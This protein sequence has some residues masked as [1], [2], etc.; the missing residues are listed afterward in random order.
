MKTVG[1]M[2]LQ[3]K[4]TAQA[5]STPLIMSSPV[6]IGSDNGCGNNAGG[7]PTVWVEDAFIE[8]DDAQIPIGDYGI[9]L[10]IHQVR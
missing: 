6:L 4:S 1:S 9:S 5:L 8:I 10:N 2:V 3:F 7:K